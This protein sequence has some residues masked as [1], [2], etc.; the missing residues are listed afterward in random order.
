MYY[1]SR[2]CSY[3]VFGS[4]SCCLYFPLEFYLWFFFNKFKKISNRNLL[5][6]RF[7][8][9][10]CLLLFCLC[11]GHDHMVG[12][13]SVR[14]T[15]HIDSYLRFVW[16]WN[17]CFWPINVFWS[18]NLLFNSLLG[19][20]PWCSSNGVLFKP[21]K[22]VKRIIWSARFILSVTSF[23]SSRFLN[24]KFFYSFYR[25]FYRSVSRM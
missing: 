5:L 2:I 15:A 6:R 13:F 14:I 9:F 11:F 25:S 7:L 10:V 4:V 21:L 12:Y 17:R 22:L 20:L 18:L 24:F 16:L 3:S 8:A 23:P 19:F 1:F